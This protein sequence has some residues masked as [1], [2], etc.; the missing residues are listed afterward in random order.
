[1]SEVQIAIIGGGVVGCAVAMELSKRHEGIFIFEKNP[2]IIRGENQSSR[3]SG[4]IHSGI[5][6]DQETR[7]LKAGL[8]V[9][10]NRLLYDFCTTNQ[11]PFIK[12]GKLIAATSCEEDRILDLYL[13]R[14]VENEVPGVT[15]IPS[16]KIKELEP[17]VLAVSALDVPAS[18]IV[19][20]SSLVYRLHTLA[21]KGGAEFITGTE[22]VDIRKG[23]GLFE[24][25][26]R[27]PDGAK[28]HVSTGLVINSA[29]V[30]A[31]LIAKMINPGSPYTID[32]ILGESYKFYSDKRRELRMGGRNIY[33]TPT[34]VRTAGNLHFTVGVHLTPTLQDLNPPY[35]T[36]STV[37]VGPRLRPLDD[38]TAK[39][40]VLTPADVFLE[41]VKK[42]FPGLKETDLSPHQ[43]GHQA[44]LK[45]YKDFIIREDSLNPGFINL[46]GIDSPGLTSCIAIARKVGKMVDRITRTD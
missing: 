40:E 15:K 16:E 11:V 35:H 29:G 39:P 5:Y 44:R 4:V 7:P 30:D 27:Y 10:G 42:Y 33:P 36:G 43:A 1:M 9:E 14:A 8:C 41:K 46:L 34:T 6:Y 25:L 3:N 37:T 23:G 18:G 22:V 28:D 24:I 38:R 17:N 13:K 45:G 12:C 26:I 20:P 19:D 2:G 31:D 32:P 21:Q